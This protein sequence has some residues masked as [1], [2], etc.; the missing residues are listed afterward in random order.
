MDR[1]LVFLCL[2]LSDC[3]LL[4]ACA[5]AAVPDSPLSRFSFS[6]NST[7]IRPV[8]G[9]EYRAEDGVRTVFFH[10]TYEDEPL[11]VPVAA[12]WADGLTGLIS[13]YGMMS[14]NGFDKNDSLLLDGTQFSVSF[15]FADGTSVTARGYGR[16][17]PNYSDATEAIE[18]HFLQLLPKD[19]RVW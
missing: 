19:M 18:A 16:F 13:Q 7:Y 1:R 11:A 17:P 14:W 9:Y 12:S 15:A 2:L 5:P 10:L 6:E 4:G 8:Q 3:M